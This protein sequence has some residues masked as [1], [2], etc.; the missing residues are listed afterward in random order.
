MESGYL[1]RA[2]VLLFHP[3]PERY[4]TGA[5]IKIGYFEEKSNLRYHDEV[6]GNLFTQINKTMDLLLTK[7]QKAIISH[8]GIQR[9]ETYPVPERALRE[10]VLNAVVHRDYA[11]AAPIQIRVY[12][13]RLY[14]WNPGELPKD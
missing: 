10:A 9:I 4:F 3:D 12:V 7:Y 6:S 11:I 8:E 14:I 5:A 1:K 2:A 13:D